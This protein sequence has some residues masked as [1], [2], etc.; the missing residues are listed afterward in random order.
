[1]QPRFFILPHYRFNGAPL[2]DLYLTSELALMAVAEEGCSDDA[3]A[4]A[5]CRR[6]TKVRGRRAASK[7]SFCAQ[8]FLATGIGLT[9]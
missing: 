4:T 8:P 7:S 3:H 5:R 2:I 9:P 1:M 6:R